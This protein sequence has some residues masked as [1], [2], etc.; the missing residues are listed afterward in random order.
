MTV[1]Y[2]HIQMKLQKCYPFAVATTNKHI[3]F[4]VLIVLFRTPFDAGFCL[5]YVDEIS[6]PLRTIYYG[7]HYLLRKGE[8]THTHKE[9]SICMIPFF[10]SL[11][12]PLHSSNAHRMVFLEWFFIHCVYAM[13]F[14]SFFRSRAAFFMVYLLSGKIKIDAPAPSWTAGGDGF[15]S[16]KN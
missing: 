7:E 3:T 10:L 5:D 4:Y 2:I 1:R 8:N 15:T 11:S 13:A 16:A 12:F 6:L 9:A 14:S